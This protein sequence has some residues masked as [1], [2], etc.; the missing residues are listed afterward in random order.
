MKPAASPAAAVSTQPATSDGAPDQPAGSTVVLV[1]TADE[2]TEP[3]RDYIILSLFSF[4]YMG[5]PFCLGLVALIFSIKARDRKLVGDMEGAQRHAY[6]AKR[7]NLLA[8]CFFGLSIFV[9]VL[10]YAFL[11]S[12]AKRRRV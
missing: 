12:N 3:P 11:V 5:N 2:S 10:V 7:F 6:T 1:D 4:V 9:I 8:L